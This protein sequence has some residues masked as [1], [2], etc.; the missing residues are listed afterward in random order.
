[1]KQNMMLKQDILKLEAGS[2]R[3]RNDL[4]RQ[5]N[6]L[7]Y[8]NFSVKKNAQL[9]TREYS[10]HDPTLPTVVITA[11]ATGSGKSGLLNKVRELLFDGESVPF[12]EFLIDDY[13]ENS[14]QYKGKV[15]NI[16]QDF[17]CRFDKQ[18][19]CNLNNPS[20]SLL[21]EFATAYFDVRNNG[22]CNLQEN[23]SCRNVMDRDLTNAIAASKNILIETTGKK[24][25]ARYMKH[26]ME[27][28]TTP[29]NVVFVY[30]MVHFGELMRRNTSRAERQME[31][32]IKSNYSSPAPR[33]PDIS[34]HAFKK[35]VSAILNIVVKLRNTCLR[36][37][38]KCGL[39]NK[40][41]KFVLLV[42]DNN[43]W[44]SKLVYD[45]R[46]TDKLMTKSDFERM[47]YDYTRRMLR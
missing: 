22:P 2:G 1:M 23:A 10:K 41:G 29:Y 7:K 16:I 9:L 3:R 19:Q 42:F 36:Q 24:L 38:S 18:H 13:V 12:E 33:L 26:I 44:D 30:S 46:S 47:I 28:A 40:N 34:E 45:S 15:N 27:K 31:T 39:I 35:A 6:R 4:R 14:S 21:D 5:Y 37:R 11:G 43:T 20:K 8:K 25:P 32:F 17:N